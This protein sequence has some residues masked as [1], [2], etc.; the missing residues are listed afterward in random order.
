MLEIIA[1]ALLMLLALLFCLPLSLSVR[2][3]RLHAT[4][5]WSIYPS[6]GIFRGLLGISL[7]LEADGRRLVPLL[8]NRALGWPS[9]RL[10]PSSKKKP[11]QASSPPTSTQSTEPVETP[12]KSTKK[13]VLIPLLRAITRPALNFITSSPHI[14]NITS[15]EL[16]GR[17]G[18]A[19]PARTGCLYGYIQALKAWD[20]K[21]LRLDLVPDF[22]T[23]GTCGQVF[24]ALHIHLGLLCIL[25]VRLVAHAG[26]RW[27]GMRFTSWKPRII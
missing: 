18:F 21:K 15:L 22:Q 26:L 12:A 20:F 7:A 24:L 5:P 16:R 25:L 8:C 13:R 17:F 27:L 2:V 4:A 3:V 10:N 1:Y 14:L 11:V 9:L 23:Q 6:L 19:D